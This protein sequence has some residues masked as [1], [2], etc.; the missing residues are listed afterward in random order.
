MR[1]A[2]PDSPAAMRPSR[3]QALAL[4]GHAGST[5]PACHKS[6]FHAGMQGV[7]AEAA[8]AVYVYRMNDFDEKRGREGVM[9]IP[10]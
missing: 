4:T 10:T 5:D 1:T 6:P 8:A 2:S 7:A 3:C 9:S